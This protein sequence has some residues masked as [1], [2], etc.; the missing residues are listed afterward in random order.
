M[1]EPQPGDKPDTDRIFNGAYDNASGCAGVLTIAQAMARAGAAAGPLDVLRVHDGGGVGAARRRVF[2]AASA[3]AD[4]LRS[5]PTS[6]STASTTSG[7]T[8]R[9]RAARRRSLDARADGRGAGQGARPRRRRRSASRARLLLPL[10]S[11]PARQG[12]RAGAVDQ[13]AAR[14]HRAERRGAAEEAG[15]LQRNGLPPAERRVRSGW[16]FT[17]AVEDMQLL[18]QLAWRIAAAPG[19]AAL[20]RG[21]SVRAGARSD[22]RSHDVR[23]ARHARRHRAPPPARDRRGTRASRRRRCIA[24][25]RGPGAGAGAARSGSSARTC[26]RWARSRFAAPTTCWRSCRPRRWRAASSPTRR[27]ITARRSRWPRSDSAPRR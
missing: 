21:R 20:Q 17:G 13:R 6:T 11:L 25:C 26:S 4:G 18:A 14:V 8:K 24:V 19:D 16:D 27:A 3:A 15:G 12:R 1:R 9:H 2:R 7:P 5:P 22:E 23:D 10:G